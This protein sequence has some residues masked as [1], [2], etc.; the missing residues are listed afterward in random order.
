[1]KK[2]RA[3]TLIELLV[4]IA[5]IAILAAMLLP[6]LAAAKRKA[7]NISCT[8]NLKQVGLGANMFA[9]DNEDYLP[10]GPDAVSANRGCSVAQMASYC[11]TSGS[12]YGGY[13]PKDWLAYYLYSYLGAAAPSP[14]TNTLKVLF[15]PSNEHYNINKNPLFFSYELAEG[16]GAGSVSRYCG[17]SW[18]PFGYNVSGYPPHKLAQVAAVGP[19]TEIWA[20]VD[21]DQRGNN[22][23][24]AAGYFPPVPSHG[25]TRNYL[26]FDW[27]VEAIKVPSGGGDSGHPQPFYRWR[28]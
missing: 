15:C 23:A 5:I 9:N 14:V 21:S 27:H 18:N 19:P 4:V 3:F 26:W 22:G 10:G 7:W 16:G 25:S 20:M 28:Q 13:N 24:G 11:S 1:M 6:A 17:L 12:L 8:S 2:T